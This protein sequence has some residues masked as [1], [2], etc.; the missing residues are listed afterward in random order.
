M[1]EAAFL[2]RLVVLGTVD[3]QWSSGIVVIVRDFNLLIGAL[4]ITNIELSTNSIYLSNDR[5]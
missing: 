2:T 4:W 5:A 1:Q 3:S